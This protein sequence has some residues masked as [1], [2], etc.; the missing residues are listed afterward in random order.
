MD[1][2]LPPLSPRDADRGSGSLRTNAARGVLINSA[3]RVGIAVLNLARTLVIVAFLTPEE[4][5]FYGLIIAAFT[6]LSFIRQ[7]G[8]SARYL[9]QNEPDQ[10]LAFQRAF[11]VELVFSAFFFV[12]FLAIVPLYAFI[13]GDKDLVGPLLVC[14]PLLLI[15]AFQA[16]IWIY[17]RRMEYFRQRVFESIDPV[18]STV[19]M[20]GLAAAGTGYWGLIAG[21]ITASVIAAIA[22][23]SASPYRLALRFDRATFRQYVSFSG[24]LIT[25]GVASLVVIQGTLMIGEAELGLAAVGAIGLAGSLARF[26]TGIETLIN[27]TLYAP[28]CAAQ[29]RIDVLR[30]VFEKSNR[31]GLMWAAP[32]GLGLTI[33]AADIVDVLGEDWRLAE[34]LL[35]IAGGIF[36]LQVVGF[37]W[38]S[39]YAARGE[40]RPSFV[41]AMLNIAAFALATVP[42]IFVLGIEGVLWG[43]AIG[44][45]AQF[46]LRSVYLRRLFHGFSILRHTVRAFAPVI[47][48][49]AAVLAVKLLVDERSLG[50]AIAELT[51]YL[52]IVVGL[53]W[54]GERPLIAET[55]GY[56]RRAVGQRAAAAA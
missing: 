13:Y 23:V 15:G 42:L 21:A 30:E 41:A 51:L 24:P 31:I 33:F 34:P 43:Q 45:A 27:R 50:L 37:T 11:S 4:F 44:A 48:A 52:A 18:L 14:S 54:R 39:F 6:S 32:F 12:C 8:V 53:T 9:Q 55:V 28:I 26:S 49:V 22:A 10:Q 5:G 35:E 38:Q 56:M 2:D 1:E 25:Y 46:V 16:P 29:D 3:F 36:A 47:P 40:T 7:N 20:I 17:Y 19:L